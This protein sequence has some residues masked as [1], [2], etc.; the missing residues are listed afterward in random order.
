MAI[1]FINT[2]NGPVDVRTLPT[3]PAPL[4]SYGECED[5]GAELE[6]LKDDSGKVRTTYCEYCDC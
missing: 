2:T 6:A 1:T 5:C 3:L 4:T